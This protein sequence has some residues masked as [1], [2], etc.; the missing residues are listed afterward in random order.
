MPHR[1]RNSGRAILAGL[2]FSLAATAVQAQRAQ[3]PPAPT[4]ADL[5]ME[6]W[7]RH[8]QMEGASLLKGVR[9]QHLGPTNISGRAT[10][11]AILQPRGATYTIF[12]AE[13]T[14]GLWRSKNEGVTW[15]PVF[16]QGPTSSIGD[17][18][19][20]SSNPSIVW[21]GTGEA[22]IFR[23][24]NAGAGVWKSTDGGDTFRH[25]G[26][27]G[28]STIPRILI[29]P[30]SPDVVF[31]AASGN[32]W[33]DNPDRGVFKTTDG[34]RTWNKVLF[35][36]NRTGAIDL[37][38]DPRDPNTLYAAT[39]QRVREKWN[40]PRNEPNYSESGIWK[41]TDG[42]ANWTQINSG[43]P[44]GRF[45]GRIGIDVARSNPNVLYAFVDNY[46]IG[47]EP[48]AGETDAYGRPRG[49]VIKGATIY[50]SD[51]AGASWRQVSESSPAMERASGTYGWVFG[52][53]RVDPNNENKVFF[54]GLGL[55]VS[56]DG[57]KTFTQLRGMHGD[58]HGLWVDP[59]NSSYMVNNND[60]GTYVSYDNGANWR[61]FRE[62]PAVQFFN[63]GADMDTPF[64]VYGSVQDHGSF[65]GVVDLTRGR[66][67]IQAT[68]WESAPGGEGSSH[69]IDPTNPA[70]VYSAGF[71]GN[72][73]RTDMHTGEAKNITPRPNE[74]EMAF[75][76]QWVAPFILSPHNPNVMYHGFNVLHRSM[77]RGDTW[78]RIS[79]DLS[80]NDPAKYGDIPY[81]T[82]FSISE[83]PFQF[84]L[85]YAGTDDGRTHIT[86]DGG[87]SWTEIA[88]TLP[89]GK[90][91]AELVASRYDKATVYLVQNGKREDD[92][93]P[94]VWKSVDYGKT[95]TS[96]AAG[97]PIGPVNV[98]RE[99]PKNR[100]I[101]YAGT[102]IGVYVTLDGGATWQTLV[103]DLP[104][105]YVH[106]LVVHDRDDILVAATH[107][108]GM[109]AI[110]VRPIQQLTPDVTSQAVSVLVSPEAGRLA[111]GGGRGGFGGGGAIRPTIYYWLKA[112]GPV[113]L[114][115]KDGAGQT[116][117][118][119]PATGDAGLNGVVWDL[120]GPG[121]APP[122]GPGGFGGGRGNL[123][124]PGVYTVE[125]RQGS[126]A[127]T[128]LVQ[129]SR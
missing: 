62:I 87:K 110:D 127:G 51:N 3:Q 100:N 76:G 35:V 8:E 4:P 32:E 41:S 95:W 129:V 90:F 11:A 46:E 91:I 14:G 17:V 1:L 85:V 50:R 58:H 24:S 15:E 7:Q 89:R 52:Q 60:G 56:E 108:R 78:E 119:L 86:M 9:W 42:G 19:V 72:I 27:V 6:W 114:T 12:V 80:H 16:D 77:D 57:G 69:A 84:G 115:L 113:T 107:G 55:N 120:T 68:A 31:V 81:Q 102:D 21:V 54:M 39:W 93:A 25:M 40:D 101:L 125:V 37:V 99:D 123:V 34:G 5:R 92:F 83:S 43:L 61:F 97:I 94:Y 106:D 74:G 79:P 71:Y 103:T 53:V 73:S 117:K 63:V 104:S 109:F 105:T 64:R 126:S 18:T 116:V 13:A 29:H 23:S 30:S 26:L 121:G 128:G 98:I 49:G 10:D 47:R 59:A 65:R 88:T 48:P 36:S 38:M 118:T 28:T 33:S 82:I 66:N 124:Q 44:E 22:N 67:M 70:T 45:R 2:T 96:I 122:A 20:A 112:A 75:R 111:A